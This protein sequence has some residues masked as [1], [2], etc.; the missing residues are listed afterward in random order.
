MRS[1]YEKFKSDLLSRAIGWDKIEP[2]KQ[3][4]VYYMDFDEP[5]EISDTSERCIVIN[6]D[7][8]DG[9]LITMT[10]Y[11]HILYNKL[12]EA[13]GKTTGISQDD[14]WENAKLS[15][16]EYN[17]IDEDMCLLRRKGGHIE[18]IVGYQCGLQ[19]LNQMILDQH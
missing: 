8:E 12:C 2:G 15:S 3:Y 10:P 16:E 1:D 4:D 9:E 17:A 19:K 18:T 6:K 7:D 5:S 13:T 14:Y 11:N